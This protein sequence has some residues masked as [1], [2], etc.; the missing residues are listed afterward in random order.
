MQMET[1]GERSFEIEWFVLFASCDR[2]RGFSV[3]LGPMR[4]G[5]IF[6]RD[7]TNCSS[8]EP[9]EVCSFERTIVRS[10]RASRRAGRLLQWV[11]LLVHSSVL[12][13]VRS[14]DRLV[15]AATVD[16]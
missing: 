11:Q 10:L 12:S 4:N 15:L 9:G 8:F 1:P 16:G 14:F 13:F 6:I 3:V 2:L 5:M 7:V